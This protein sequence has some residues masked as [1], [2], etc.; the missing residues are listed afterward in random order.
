V[1]VLYEVASNMQLA[2]IAKLVL[3]R[4]QALIGGVFLAHGLYTRQ[5]PNTDHHNHA[6]H[7]PVRWHMHQVRG[8]SQSANHDSESG[9][10]NSK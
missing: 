2:M 10:V 7:N 1:G 3:G 9:S 8:I 5:N 4:Q 6:H